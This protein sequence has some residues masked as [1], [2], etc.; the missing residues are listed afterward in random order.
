MGKASRGC[1]DVRE[2]L[3]EH[4]PSR[5]QLPLRLRYKGRPSGRMRHGALSAALAPHRDALTDLGMLLSC[6]RSLHAHLYL[7]PEL[8][9]A[10]ATPCPLACRCM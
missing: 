9:R 6:L 10:V 4:P 1:A 3:I 8:R 5:E 2:Q 7:T